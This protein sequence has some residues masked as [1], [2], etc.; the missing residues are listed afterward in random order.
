VLTFPLAEQIWP[1][2]KAAHHTVNVVF[3]DGLKHD[4]AKLI[5]QKPYPGAGLYAVLA[6]KLRR[7]YKLAF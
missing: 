1:L 2:G 3:R 7:D 5:F 6:S 4:S